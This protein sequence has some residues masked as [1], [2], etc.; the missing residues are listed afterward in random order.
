MFLN[1]IKEPFKLRRMFSTSCID[2]INLRREV[3]PFTYFQFKNSA[4]KPFIIEEFDLSN[5]LISRNVCI[6]YVFF[7]LANK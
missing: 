7:S 5:S 3:C 1:K 2:L 4:V 6:M